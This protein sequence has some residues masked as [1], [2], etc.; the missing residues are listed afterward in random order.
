MGCFLLGHSEITLLKATQNSVTSF[1]ERKQER[2][3]R[4]KS[5]VYHLCS[6]KFS[7]VYKVSIHVVSLVFSL[8]TSRSPPGSHGAIGL[9]LENL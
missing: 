5:L 2:V 9:P 1:C 6:S 3:K 8:H 7:G 4:E